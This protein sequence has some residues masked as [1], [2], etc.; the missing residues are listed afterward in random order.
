MPGRHKKS[1]RIVAQDRKKYMDRAE[2]SERRRNDIQTQGEGKEVDNRLARRRSTK[3][4]GG[5]VVEVT[6]GV[7]PSSATSLESPSSESSGGRPVFKWVKGDLIGRGTYGR[8]YLALNAT[9]GEMIAVK[10]VELPTTASD[11][12]DIRQK[13]VVA[14]LKSEIETLKDLDHPNIVSYLG[15]EETRQTLSIFLEYVPGGSVGSCLRKHGKLEEATIKSFLNQILEGLSYLHGR[16]I[17]HR[18]LKADNLLVD[19]LGTVKISDFGTV[20]K[21]EDIYGNVASMSVQGSIFWMAPEVMSLSS[22]GYSAKVDI[23]SLGC[24]VLE[25]FAGRR[26]WS[27]EEAVHAMF[28]IGAERKAPPIPPDVRLSKAATHFLKTCF[29]VDPTKRPTASR[30]LE[31]V[32]PHPLEG[33]HFEQSSLYRHLSK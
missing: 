9:T 20:R 17:L 22:R 5:R 13:N 24:V 6:P 10:Q 28:K 1:I 33:W 8:V 4:W 14:A 25:M 31:H 26:P 32:F 16:N 2:A 15:Y 29:Y 21:S 30:L 12:E 19:H 11:R 23:W 7:D 27:E 3:L 18:D